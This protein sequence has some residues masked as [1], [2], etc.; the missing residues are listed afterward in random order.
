MTEEKATT[1]TS[2]S[3]KA[4]SWDWLWPTVVAVFIVKLFGIAGGL[5]TFGVHYWLKP[6][7]GNLGAVAVAGVTGAVI[8]IGLSALIRA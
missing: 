6:K 5:V 1:V 2:D 8:A 3:K 7:L 4:S